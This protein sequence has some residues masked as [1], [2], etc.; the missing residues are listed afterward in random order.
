MIDK[1]SWRWQRNEPN[2]IN[3]CDKHRIFSMQ[4]GW[5][6][7]PLSVLLEKKTISH[8]SSLLF[9]S[10]FFFLSFTFRCCRNLKLN[11]TSANYCDNCRCYRQQETY[12]DIIHTFGL[13]ILMTSVSPWKTKRPRYRLASNASRL[14]GSQPSCIARRLALRWTFFSSINNVEK[15]RYSWLFLCIKQ[16]WTLRNMYK[17][18]K[19]WNN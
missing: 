2:N 13:H 10:V 5:R 3:E 4:Y 1:R 9:R 18:K 8:N 6:G 7:K 11:I 14:L 19:I 16:R 17:R 15:F 12:F